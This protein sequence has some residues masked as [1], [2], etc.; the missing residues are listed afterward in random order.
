[1]Q[2]F[3]L[4]L[5][6]NNDLVDQNGSQDQGDQNGSQ[7]LGDTNDSRNLCY[8]RKEQRMVASKLTPEFFAI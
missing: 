7:N 3:K 2:N 1:M 5:G 6:I 8:I 4:N